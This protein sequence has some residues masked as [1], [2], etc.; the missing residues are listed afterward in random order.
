MRAF[1]VT[2]CCAAMLLPVAA[3]ASP[4]LARQK[5]CMGCHALDKKQV[6]PS[7]KDIATRYAGQKDAPARMADKIVRGGSGAWGPVPMPA[8]PKVTPDEAKRLA[9][10]ILSLK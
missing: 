4:D 6:G 2:I 5:L 7:F 3:L 10:W 9:D 1:A 8:N